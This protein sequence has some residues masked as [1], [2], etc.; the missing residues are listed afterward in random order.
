MRVVL[1]EGQGRCARIGHMVVLAGVLLAVALPTMAGAESCPNEEV[2]AE[3]GS[4]RLPDCRAFE[5]VTPEVK[6]DNSTIGGANGNP[7]G[8][9]D[10]N[11]VYYDT[12]L[13]LPGAQSGEDEAVLS[14]RA[15]SGWV[16]TPLA[17]PAGPG[18][19]AGLGS[20]PCGGC[21]TGAVAFTGD[22]SAAFVTSGFDTDLQ[23][24]DGALDAYR[25][26]LSSGASSL[27]ALPDTGP[28]TTSFNGV[29]PGTFVAGVSETGS[30]VFFQTFDQLPV[31]P[32]TP[33][34]HTGDM[35]YD[36]TGG[37]T[38]AVGVLPNGTISQ[39]CSTE[40]GNGPADANAQ[41]YLTEGAISPDGTNV[42]FTEFPTS[43]VRHSWCVSA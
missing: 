27:A 16:N 29:N 26:D 20:Q 6:G 39:T 15:A 25:I 18:E 41:G 34:E 35:L 3:Q 4:E 28:M 38:Y 13:P 22:F 33:G 37:H 12:L 24:Q 9:P 30:H 11:H 23:D 43:P 40:L 31:A 14:T 1:E 7:L 19:P 36:R 42:V 8:F 21:W 5:L 10:G 2:R 32:G 17:P